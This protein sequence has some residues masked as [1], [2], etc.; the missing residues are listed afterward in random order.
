MVDPDTSSVVDSDTSSATNA[1]VSSVNNNSPELLI[2]SSFDCEYDSSEKPRATKL[3]AC[4][5]LIPV[6]RVAIIA[7]VDRIKFFL[8]IIFIKNLFFI[9]NKQLLCSPHSERNL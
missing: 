2:A 3:P 1:G 4:T 7:T 6:Y 8:P 9:I 5:L